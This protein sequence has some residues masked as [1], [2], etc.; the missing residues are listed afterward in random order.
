MQF[1]KITMQYFTE[2]EKNLKIHM[3]AQ[4]TLESQSKP[5]STGGVTIP[6]FKFYYRDAT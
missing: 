3:A 4:K 5:N 6:E 2:I 1:H